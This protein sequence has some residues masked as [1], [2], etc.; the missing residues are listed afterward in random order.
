MASVYHGKNIFTT[1]KFPEREFAYHF[2]C[3]KHKKNELKE[4]KLWP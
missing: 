3:G 1:A 2:L 4:Q